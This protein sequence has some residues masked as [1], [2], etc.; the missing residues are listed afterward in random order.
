MN[1]LSLPFVR[2]FF[3]FEY[4]LEH[5]LNSLQ[6][7]TLYLK[8]GNLSGVLCLFTT[9][10]WC[11]CILIG[12]K[13]LPKCSIKRLPWVISWRHLTITRSTLFSPYLNFA[14]NFQFVF[15][16]CC[17]RWTLWV[18]CIRVAKARY[19]N[20]YQSLGYTLVPVAYP[21]LNIT[22]L[23]ETH[24]PEIIQQ[25]QQFPIWSCLCGVWGDPNVS[26]LT[27]VSIATYK[28]AEFNR[29]TKKFEK[30]IL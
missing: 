3:Q 29:P 16:L 12:L 7:L 18:S 22:L 14:Q 11:F 6:I 4:K 21:S 23:T 28:E 27:L 19:I 26:S 15:D 9:I 17:L 5:C 24:S 20:W 1:T 8:C 30:T 13:R 25:Q 2:V 10:K